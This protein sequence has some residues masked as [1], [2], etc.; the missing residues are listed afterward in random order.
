MSM[1]NCSI[2]IAVHR[3]FQRTVWKWVFDSEMSKGLCHHSFNTP[4]NVKYCVVPKFSHALLLLAVMLVILYSQPVSLV[5]FSSFYGILY[6]LDK[7]I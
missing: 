4:T 7:L 1:Y 2:A 6:T 5:I 3:F